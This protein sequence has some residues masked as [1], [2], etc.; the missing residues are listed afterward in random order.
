[1]GHSECIIGHAR[2]NVRRGDEV[3]ML[4]EITGRKEI[5]TGNRAGKYTTSDTDYFVKKN[6]YIELKKCDEKLKKCIPSAAIQKKRK[7]GPYNCIKYTYL[8]WKPESKF[9]FEKWK[10]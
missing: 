10:K 2:P 4:S 7:Y 3:T 6:A 8:D 9:D 5:L 1:M